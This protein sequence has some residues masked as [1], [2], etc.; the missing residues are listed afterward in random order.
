MK[1]FLEMWAYMKSSWWNFHKILS[2]IFWEKQVFIQFLANIGSLWSLSSHRFSC[3]FL[4]NFHHKLYLPW[5]TFVSQIIILLLFHL[6]LW[7]CQLEAKCYRKNHHWAPPNRLRKI[8][9]LA[10]L[11]LYVTNLY[12]KTHW[13][14]MKTVG[15][16]SQNVWKNIVL[17][18]EPSK[19][20][21]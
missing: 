13:N 4:W 18:Y 10:I 1:N 3:Q 15:V 16:D 6:E 14:R 12:K 7:I 19:F 11:P 21:Y 8:S 5:V 2:S 9:W 17:K 20:L